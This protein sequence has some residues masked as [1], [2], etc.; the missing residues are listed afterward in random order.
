LAVITLLG[1]IPLQ[2]Y[3]P[4]TT[5]TSIN[6]SPETSRSY[7][8]IEITVPVVVVGL[9]LLLIVGLVLWRKIR[10]NSSKSKGATIEL[11]NIAK[12]K[13]VKIGDKLGVGNFG[14]IST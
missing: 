8:T 4:S 10:S 6:S 2:P 11:Q 5:T 3:T 13:N 12:I 1:N 9:C 7:T 14:T